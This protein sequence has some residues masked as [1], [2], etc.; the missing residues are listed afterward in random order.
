M[1]LADVLE[2]A[3]RGEGF[4]AY[5]GLDTPEHERLRS[6]L[7]DVIDE[8]LRSGASPAL[9]EQAERALAEQLGDPVQH[10]RF[11][12]G[13]STYR[14]G[15]DRWFHDQRE[16][17]EARFAGSGAVHLELGTWTAWPT[18]RATALADADDLAEVI[19]LDFE[20]TYELDVVADA[21]LLPFRDASL[22]RI[23]ADS[24][25]E[26]VPH[27]HLVLAECFRVLKPG[28]MLKLVTPF[29]FN[30]HGYPDDYLRYTP[31]WYRTILGE[32]GFET[33]AADVEAT[34]GLFYTLHNAAK[35][36][37]I[38][39][40]GPDAAALRTLHL[41]VLELLGALVPLDDGFT[42]GGRNW[43]TAVECFALK[44]G[45]YSPPHRERRWN[46]PWVDRTI[47]LLSEPGIDS[48]LYRDGDRLVA[49]Q[50][51][52]TY[53][54][55]EGIPHFT[56]QTPVTG[57]DR[58]IERARHLARRAARRLPLRRDRTR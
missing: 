13:V 35:S 53:P 56:G 19:R 50:T 32:V 20:P 57:R 16:Q 28:G 21:R 6:A 49:R 41:L 10:S 58:E 27:P 52:A 15:H 8:A 30:L 37:V 26:H 3:L 39:P 43:F 45:G 22:D 5:A 1:P 7:L 24:V 47:D 34:R 17:A 31:S 11:Y 36:A 51:G 38:D 42:N 14:W 23:S 12:D 18:E 33:V 2:T 55:R 46:V 4:N 54:I 25:I 9:G 40:E 29:A 48:E 44:A